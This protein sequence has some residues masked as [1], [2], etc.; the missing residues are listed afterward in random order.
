MRQPYELSI[1]ARY[2]RA[3]RGESF[4]S[5]I[6]LV[7]MIGIGLAVAVLIV[8]TSVMDG[9]EYEL[10][11]RILGVASHASINALDRRLDEWGELRER[12][13]GRADVVGAA[14]FVEGQGMALPDDIGGNGEPA[15][16]G[17]EAA[18]DAAESTPDGPDDD[19]PPPRRGGHLRVVK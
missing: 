2:L 11:R 9:F 6:S 3:R 8:V 13:L 4:I 15:Q 18:A 10:Q 5:F 16:S 14:P 7:S 19:D 12:A 17:A 1:A